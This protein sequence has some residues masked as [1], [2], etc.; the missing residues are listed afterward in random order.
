MDQITSTIV[1]LT[2]PLTFKEKEIAEIEIRTPTL[3][4]MR[5]AR[6]E[7][8]SADKVGDDGMLALLTSLISD[9]SLLPKTTVEKISMIDIQNISEAFNEVFPK[10]AANPLD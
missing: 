6:R 10:S 9:Q 2:S 4:E 7:Q 1:T 8:I 5:K 3:G